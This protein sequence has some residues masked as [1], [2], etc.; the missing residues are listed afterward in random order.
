M[1]LP[2]IPLSVVDHARC[3]QEPVQLIGCIPPHGVLFAL[4]ES[5]L[6]V[7]QVSTNVTELLG[8]SGNAG[9]I[10]PTG[11]RSKN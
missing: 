1:I 3:S 4:S 11:I 5:D 2:T 8:V 10:V 9:E 6:L 7:R